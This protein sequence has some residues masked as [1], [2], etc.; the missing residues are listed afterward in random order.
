[1]DNTNFAEILNGLEKDVFDL[2]SNLERQ[3][4]VRLASYGSGSRIPTK[5]EPVKPFQPK[6]RGLR[7]A[8][9]WLWKGH[10]R[11]N[12]DY[13]DLYDKEAK[14]ESKNGRATLAEYLLDVRLIDG[15]AEEICSEVLGDFLTESSIDISDLS[16]QFV[17][18]FRNIIFK[19]KNLIKSAGP[20][21]P[22]VAP[23]ATGRMPVTQGAPAQA[24]KPVEPKPPETQNSEPASSQKA[25][26]E[27][28]SDGDKEEAPAQK[29]A[30]SEE[31]ENVPPA[32]QEDGEE[33][34]DSGSVSNGAKR[35]PKSHSANIGRWFKDAMDAKKK[36]GDGLN[37]KPEWL[38]AK[39]IVKPEKLPWVIA[40]MGTKSHKDLQ[41]DED[42]KSELQSAIGSSFKDFVTQIAKKKSD[43]LVGYLRKNMPMVSDEEFKRL[44]SELYGSEYDGPGAS[45]QKKRRDK[46]EDSA[47][48]AAKEDSADSAENSKGEKEQ[49]PDIQEK[50][51]KALSSL[52]EGMDK[53]DRIL[54]AI[55]NKIIRPTFEMM[56]SDEDKKYFVGWWKS[57]K[58]ERINDGQEDMESM[59]VRINTLAMFNDILGN[60]EVSKK[61]PE[62]KIKLRNLMDML[63]G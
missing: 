21:S 5:N 53:K 57:F 11:D 58:R 26:E 36:G 59:I 1:M 63:K 3:I 14:S 10:S 29:G 41:K 33:N 34:S 32:A 40:W 51:T 60:S 12:P 38:N 56:D 18:D 2:V 15:F 46:K 17:L 31:K 54:D 9:R 13:A 35:K 47:D 4:N 50:R 44:V 42:V 52:Y 28:S 8:L 39:G 22:E 43:S 27:G 7:G 25:S 62:K 30:S 48:S 19:Y 37:P 20:A 55:E 45:S 23:A 24:S 6:W 61:K 49:E 16:R